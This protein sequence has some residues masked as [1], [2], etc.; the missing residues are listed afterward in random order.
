MDDVV[1]TLEELSIDPTQKPDES[2]SCGECG[3]KYKK[4]W[5]LKTHM[6]KKHGIA[7]HE[8]MHDKI[9]VCEECK[10]V[11]YDKVSLTKHVKYHFVCQICKRVCDSKYALNRHIRSH[12]V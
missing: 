1:G 4:P 12:K 2:L 10:E 5:T 9:L 3:A 7:K 6:S 8:Q 11:F